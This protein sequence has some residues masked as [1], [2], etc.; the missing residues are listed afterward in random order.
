MKYGLVVI[1]EV[2]NARDVMART[3]ESHLD[4]TNFK[5]DSRDSYVAMTDRTAAAKK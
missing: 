1:N 3:L 2:K 4:C 5:T